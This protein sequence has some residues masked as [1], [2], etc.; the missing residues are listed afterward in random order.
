[1]R[2]ELRKILARV[3]VALLIFLIGVVIY[4]QGNLYAYP[5]LENRILFLLVPSGIVLLYLYLEERETRNRLFSVIMVT[6]GRLHESKFMRFCEG[7]WE[8]SPSLVHVRVSKV[9]AVLYIYLHKMSGYML[10]QD[11]KQVFS[12]V[13]LGMLLIIALQSVIPQPPLEWARTPVMIAAVALGVVTFYLNRDKLGEIEEEARQEEIEE[14]RREME[15]GGKYPRINRVWGMRWVVRW[16]Y[17]EGWWYSGGVVLL[18]LIA[19]SIRVYNLMILYP[20]TDEYTHLMAA[21]NLLE[22]G[23]TDYNRAY[24]LTYIVSLLFKIFGYSLYIARLPGVFFGAITVVPIYLLIRRVSK[25]SAMISAW[26]WV[27]SPWAIGVSRNL[28]EYAIFPFFILLYLVFIIPYITRIIRIIDGKIRITWR[29]IFPISVLCSPIIYAFYIDP[30]SSFKLITLFILP[31]GLYGLYM[32]N[33]VK[34]PNSKK[35]MRYIIVVLPFL[36]LLLP[37][38]RTVGF[39]HFKPQFNEYWLNIFF[40][41]NLGTPMHWY[42]NMQLHYIFIL[43]VILCGMVYIMSAKNITGIL[44]V[45]IFV[46][47]LYFFIFH[48]DRYVRPRYIFYLLPFFIFLI[49]FGLFSIYK[50]TPNSKS[51]NIILIILLLVLFNPLNAYY[52]I[53]Y[54]KHGY[55]PMT[56]EYHDNISQLI[57]SYKD[58]IEKDDIVITSLGYMLQWY[59]DRPIN[60]TNMFTWTYDNEN[61]FENVSEIVS[62]NS[63]GWIVLDWRRNGRWTKGLPKDDFETGGK[64]V[65]FLGNY[66]GFHVYRWER[67]TTEL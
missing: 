59:F 45:L 3:F 16:M 57:Q 33:K 11:P 2:Q 8:R 32:L 61:R 17:K 30:L 27:I 41:L 13:F 52:A 21:K 9:L 24:F 49:G 36:V 1:M 6:I 35:Y 19:F 18:V 26:L 66:G 5:G 56:N 38:L 28:R 31:V 60:D 46:I 54:E 44:T 4:K 10:K 47:G 37:H 7:I 55:V 29:E 64:E 65:K 43:F 67:N 42:Y 62:D 58:K 23:T 15:F 22:T 12:H 34:S 53:T 50:L 39:M 20:Y 51:K 40:D 14:K 63:E 25:P 48:F